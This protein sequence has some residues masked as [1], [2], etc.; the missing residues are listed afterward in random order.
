MDQAPVHEK[1]HASRPRRLFAA[2]W[3]LAIL[4]IGLWLV[5]VVTSSMAPSPN[6][7]SSSNHVARDIV[8]GDALVS[9][10]SPELAA[11]DSAAMGRI[12]LAT[13]Q[14]GCQTGARAWRVGRGGAQ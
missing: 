1:K 4:F 7:H 13:H 14:R 5:V 6:W 9:R 12:L 2:L 11:A 10:Q 8:D 3:V